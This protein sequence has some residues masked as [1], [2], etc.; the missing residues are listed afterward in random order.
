MS[1]RYPNQDQNVIQDIDF[2]VPP[3]KKV[4]IVGPSGSGKSTLTKFLPRFYDVSQG[5][6]SIDGV[7]VRDWEL[8]RLRDTIGIVLQDIHLF[9]TTIRENILYGNQERSHEEMIQAAILAHAHEFITKLPQGYD[10]LIGAR[11]V[12]L[13]G[14][15][16]Q[17]VSLARTILRNPAVLIL[18]E[19]TSS[20][21]SE[22]EITVMRALKEVSRNRTTLIVAHRLS[23]IHDCDQI[24]FCEQG[25][26]VE[27]GNHEA[28]MALGGRY[29]SYVQLQRREEA[30]ADGENL[31]ELRPRL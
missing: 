18:D 9:N 7:D 4:A 28:L 10:T 27:R 19:A 8:D 11:G 6:V 24:L 20:L 16:K 12:K 2:E 13:S 17:R 14:G 1:Y 22:S 29:A 21:D 26:I 23:T 30:L 15:E 25:R 3:G 5:S 31:D